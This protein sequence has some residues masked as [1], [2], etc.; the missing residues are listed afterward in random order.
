MRR[1]SGVKRSYTAYIDF[2][3][4]RQKLAEAARIGLEAAEAG[5]LRGMVG[6]TEMAE[7]LWLEFALRLYPSD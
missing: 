6:V 1:V 7:A 2:H 4:T 5:G 3:P